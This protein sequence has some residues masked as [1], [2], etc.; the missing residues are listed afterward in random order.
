MSE[1]RAPSPQRASGPAP[2][3]VVEGLRVAF[4]QYERGLRR[5]VVEVV[6]GMDLTVETGELVAVVGASGAGKTLLAHAVLGLLPPNAVETG[7][8]RVDGVEVAPSGRRH[9]AGRD[10]ALLP[11]SVTSL[12]PLAS[13]GSQVRRAATLAGRPDPAAAAAAALAARRLGPEVASL[14]PHEL[15]GGMARRVLEAIATMGTPRLLFA[16]EPTPGLHAEAAAATLARLRAMADDGTA[17]VLITH[18]LPGA[19]SVA[20]RVVVCR[21][22]RTVEDAPASAFRDDGSAL[23][24]DYA[25]AL[26]RALPANGLHRADGTSVA[27]QVAG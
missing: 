22:G 2:L 21:A 3:L 6:S 19:L 12:D 25:R 1:P 13:V 15:S 20:D 18:E 10:L 5:R 26:W 4:V 27:R 7:R 23:R 24:T 9:L 8:V 14:R 16:D 17:V 11:Q